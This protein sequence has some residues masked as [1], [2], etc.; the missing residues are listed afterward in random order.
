VAH[1]V[2][3]DEGL[4]PVQVGLLGANAVVKVSNALAHLVHQ[5]R[6]L[7]RG[8]R[9]QEGRLGVHGWAV[10]TVFVYSILPGLVGV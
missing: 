2:K 4:D 3:M 1:A 6:C 5:P 8:Q 10:E 9:R 7:D